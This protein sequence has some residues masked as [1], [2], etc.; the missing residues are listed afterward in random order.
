MTRRY[1]AYRE[2]GIDWLGEV[3]QHWDVGPLKRRYSVTLGKMLQPD[4]KSEQDVYSHYLRAANV[5]WGRVDVS[6]MNSMW[7]S[8]TETVTLRLEIGDLLVSEGGDVGRSA[9]WNGELKECYFQNSVNRVRPNENAST[10]YLYYWMATIKAKG[11]VDVLCNKSTIAHFTAEK[12]EA[13]PVPMPPLPEQ[14]A[15]AA[16]LDK[17]TAKIDALVEEQRRLIDLLREKRQAVVSHAVTRGLNVDAKLK[18]S[19][20]DWLGD[21]P[22]GWE[23]KPFKYLVRH[24]N[25][26]Q[27]GPFGGMLTNLPEDET[28]FKLYGQ[29][30]VISGDFGRGRRWVEP[31]RFEELAGYRILPGDLVMTRKGSIGN[32]RIF[33]QEA[34]AG[35]ADSDTIRVRLNSDMVD[36]ELLLITLQEAHFIRVQFDLTKRGAILSGLNTAVVSNLLLPVAPLTEQ[37]EILSFV[38]TETAKWEALLQEAEAAIDLLQERRAAFISA[39]VTGKID[40]RDLVANQT[41]AA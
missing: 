16:F 11:Y 25:G 10:A 21:V 19:G 38:R 36:P 41:E 31:S 30:N 17:E 24:P 18:P 26:I 27:M 13:V 9:I 37:V 5:Q 34:Q 40:V 22:E 28:A 12:V 3:P 7:F 15:I 33:P 35:I 1:Q 4:A 20:E 23:V 2:S 8:P 29:E 39:A 6:D 32:C 14:T